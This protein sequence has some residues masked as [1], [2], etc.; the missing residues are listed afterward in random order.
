ME[1]KKY[2]DALKFLISTSDIL[3]NLRSPLIKTVETYMT[4][5]KNEHEEKEFER[6]LKEVEK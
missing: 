1:E 6:L 2:K 4:R 5:I 3:K